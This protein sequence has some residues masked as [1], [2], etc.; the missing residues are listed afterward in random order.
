[1]LKTITK[2]QKMELLGL[3]TLARQHRKLMDLAKE[4]AKEIMV[5]DDLDD[6]DSA[7]L[8][9]VFEEKTTIEEVLS[10]SEVN[11]IKETK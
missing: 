3:L 7:F 5:S 4:A 10:T 1:M 11:I 8:D 9:A 2:Q 6:F